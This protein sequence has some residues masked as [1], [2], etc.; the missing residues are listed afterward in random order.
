MTDTLSLSRDACLGDD[1]RALFRGSAFNFLGY[2]IKLA[3]PVL[4]AACTQLFGAARFG[5]FITAQAILMIT[6]RVCM[7]GLDKGLL[8]WVPRQRAG[9]ELKGIRPS[10]LLA[11]AIS[12]AAALLIAFAIAPPLAVWGGAPEAEGALRIMAFGIVPFA[13]MDLL[14]HATMGKRRMEANVIVKDIL[15]PLSLVGSAIAFD[16]SGLAETGLALAFLFSNLIGLAGAVLAFRLMFKGSKWPRENAFVPPRALL[17]YSLPM[18]ASEIANAFLQRIDTLIVAFFLTPQAVGV[19][20]VVTLFGNAIRAI[21]RS[22]DP[23]VTAVVSHIGGAADAPVDGG[24]LSAN[25]SCA[26][27]LVTATQLPIFAFLLCF[28]T[29][30]LPLFGRGFESGTDA[31]LI[32]AGFFAVN[33][34]GGLA[35]LVVTGLGHSRLTLL[36]VLIAIAAQ[37]IFLFV[38]VAPHGL[39]F[40]MAGAALAVGLSYSLQNLVQ[41]IEMKLV[42]G[43][44]NYTRKVLPPALIGFASFA[45]MGAVWCLHSHFG[46]FAW[47]SVSFAAFVIVYGAGMFALRRRLREFVS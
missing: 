16:L 19:W 20:A 40:G 7:L 11:G 23:I 31:V 42:A 12:T 37:V 26:W 10:L 33:G 32:L 22:F 39:D 14:I 21:R 2:A 44:W 9:N 4:L 43:Q 29:M 25:F 27:V 6:V 17:K 45:A 1:A 18:G 28:A 35:G 15:S 3:Y 30:L 5:V 46:D 8:F 36:N 13:L 41:H 34:A 24:R 47:R 38:F